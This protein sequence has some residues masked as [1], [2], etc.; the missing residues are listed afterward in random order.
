MLY[1]V[2]KTLSQM[3][4]PIETIYNFKV[5]NLDGNLV[6]LNNKKNKVILIVNSA[7]KWGLAQTNLDNL[8]L[9]KKKYNKNLSI[10][11]FPSNQFNQENKSNEELKAYVSE[12]N[13]KYDFFGKIIL[14]GSGEEPLYKFLKKKTPGFKLREDINWNFTKFLCINGKPVKRFE[15]VSSFSSIENEIKKYL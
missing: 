11:M 2:K 15:P 9:L 10:W 6:D 4:N 8:D 1:K 3:S 14:N 5:P 7:S 13:I 12:K